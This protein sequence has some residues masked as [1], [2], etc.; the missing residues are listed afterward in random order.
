MTPVLATSEIMVMDVPLVEYREKFIGDGVNKFFDTPNQYDTENILVFLNG[1]LQYEGIAFDRTR[2]GIEFLNPVD[3]GYEVVLVG[4]SYLYNTV[5]FTGDGVTTTFDLE[6][7]TETMLVLASINGLVQHNGTAFN[8][9]D[10][11]IIFSE[12]IPDGVT[13]EV[14]IISQSFRTGV[15]QSVNGQN[16][17]VIDNKNISITTG[18]NLIKYINLD[19]S[20]VYTPKL[21]DALTVGVPNTI[22]LWNRGKYRSAKYIVQAE[23]GDDYQMAE[24]LVIHSN[25]TVAVSVFG[26]TMTGGD[27]GTIDANI[28]SSNVAVTFT[29]TNPNTRVKILKEYVEL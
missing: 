1:I 28:V 29:P 26:V 5:Q 19:G 6:T 4:T 7:S 18:G 22:D 2:D 12:P 21:S 25:G 10:R 24:V 11:E 16:K 14:V 27:L 23:S 13:V 8:V 9:V 20:V 17:V 15:I 3:V